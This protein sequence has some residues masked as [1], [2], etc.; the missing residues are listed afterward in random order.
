MPHSLSRK[1]VLH[2]IF[3]LSGITT[4]LIGQVLPVLAKHFTLSDLQ[5]S[6]FFP[7][8]F[9]GSLLGTLLT[10]IAGKRNMYFA[11]T[12]AGSLLMAGGIILMNVDIFTVCLLGFAINGMG[13]GLTLP[14]INMLILE[15]NP[16]RAG[17]ALSVLNFCWGLGAIVCKPFVDLFGTADHLGMTTWLL[18]IP[19]AI[20]AAVLFLF[21]AGRRE[22]TAEE[23]WDVPDT[24]PI[25]TTP[26]AWMI[27]AFNFI[28]V[29]FESGIGGWLTTYTGRV[30]GDPLASWVSPTLLYFLFFVLGRGFAPVLFRFLNESKMLI[31]GL[32]IILIGM[33]VILSAPTVLA[34]SLGATIAGFGTS[35]IFPT[36]VARFSQTFGPS[37]SRRATP[38]F[39]L[40]TLG[41]ALSTWLIGYISDKTGSLHSGMYVLLA[42]VMLLIILQIAIGTRPVAEARTE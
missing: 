32:F 29:G 1:I 19:I 3:F 7:A 26:I 5:V 6:Y 24:T 40:G 38:L 12:I 11:A 34:L 21:G 37:A 42:A 17:S 4:V 28:H 13:I 23:S 2:V 18:A 16:D 25:W 10:S 39:I 30:P 15:A 9:A 33:A 36:N 14:A 8:Q 35:W 31:L 20:G 22:T 41:S 27:A